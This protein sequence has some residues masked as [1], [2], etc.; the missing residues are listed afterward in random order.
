MYSDQI[1][2]LPHISLQLLMTQGTKWLWWGWTQS[3]LTW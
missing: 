3:T 2:T 1:N